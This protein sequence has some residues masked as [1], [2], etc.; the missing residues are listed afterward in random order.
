MRPC[1]K[2]IIRLTAPLLTTSIF[3]DLNMLLNC[4]GTFRTQARQCT[5][6]NFHAVYFLAL[7][8]KLSI[9]MYGKTVPQA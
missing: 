5:P 6:R 7:L 4:N 1:Q 2:Q 3:P 9:V 8:S